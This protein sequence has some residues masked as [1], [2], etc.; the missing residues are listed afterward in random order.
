M[1]SPPKATPGRTRTESSSR[2]PSPGRST[3][4]ASSSTD[5]ASKVAPAARCTSLRSRPVSGRSTGS[6]RSVGRSRSGW[7]TPSTITVTSGRG[8]ASGSVATGVRAATSSGGGAPTP[9]RLRRSSATSRSTCRGATSWSNSWARRS[10][11]YWSSSWSAPSGCP[12]R[13]LRSAVDR[14]QIP[15]VRCEG[16]SSPSA[17]S[18]SKVTPYFSAKAAY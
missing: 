18:S 7:R 5:P 9:I 6:P 8:C 12:F 13:I 11:T 14:Q 17:S 3:V 2:P 16:Q 10:T 15:P 1:A 4:R